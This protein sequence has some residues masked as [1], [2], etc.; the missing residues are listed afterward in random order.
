II[1]KRDKLIFAYGWFF[2]VSKPKQK[3]NKTKKEKKKKAPKKE[4]KTV[5]RETFP[6]GEISIPLKEKENMRSLYHNKEYFQ[7]LK[8]INSSNIPQKPI[9]DVLND[10]FF[11]NEDIPLK[12]KKSIRKIIYYQKERVIVVKSL[13]GDMMYEQ[14]KGLVKKYGW[15]F[16]ITGVPVGES[17][18][19]EAIDKIDKKFDSDYFKEIFVLNGDRK[20]K[21]RVTIYPIVLKPNHNCHILGIGNLNILL[22]CGI[23]EPEDKDKSEKKESEE[24]VEQLE[25]L[26]IVENNEVSK[27]ETEY[28]RPDDFKHIEDYLQNL[29]RLIGELE[30]NESISEIFYRN[31]LLNQ[32][33]T[34]YL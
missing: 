6:F 30:Q 29:L 14:L 9:K 31:N 8:L 16:Y 25:K 3:S 2:F 11:K 5:S 26:K 34:R 24:E 33:L 22:D 18:I 4:E 1:W 13:I 10:L 20:E 12:E 23:S 28:K 19:S 27:K 21:I 17:N 15:Y 7:Y 32:K